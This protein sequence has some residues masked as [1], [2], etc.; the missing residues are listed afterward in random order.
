MLAKF[1]PGGNCE[2]FYD[3]GNKSSL[4]IP[5]WLK[6]KGLTAYEYECGKG[7]KISADSAKSLGEKAAEEGIALSVHALIL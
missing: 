6:S 4:Q 7:I 1:G 5:V 3:E 2:R